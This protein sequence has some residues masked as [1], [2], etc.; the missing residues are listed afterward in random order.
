V[1]IFKYP[2]VQLSAKVHQNAESGK[3]DDPYGP[4]PVPSGR[5]GR[6]GVS[7]FVLRDE[8]DLKQ[9]PDIGMASETN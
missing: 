3:R 8:I 5:L 1:R 2:F 7:S 4:S 9:T 6:G